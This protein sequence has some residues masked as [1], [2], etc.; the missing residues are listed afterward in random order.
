MDRVE[1]FVAGRKIGMAVVNSD[2]TI[3]AC[4]EYFKGTSHMFQTLLDHI[5]PPGEHQLHFIRA[6][7]H[8][9]S[10]PEF[11]VQNESVPPAS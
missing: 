10:N 2:G 5:C 11:S 4:G 6:C 9:V 7:L 8:G 1:C 3:E